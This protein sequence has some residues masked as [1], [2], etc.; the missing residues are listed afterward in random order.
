MTMTKG[1]VLFI[2]LFLVIAVSNPQQ[3]LASEE[4]RMQDEVIYM[5]MVDRFNN[6]N[7]SN[8][9][10]ANINDPLAYHGGDFQGITDKL[11]Y[12]KEMGYTAIWLTPI[13]ENMNNG[14]HGYWIK[15]FY[16]T[17]PY[18]GSMEEFKTLVTEAHKRDIKVILDFVVNHVGP[19]HEWLNDSTKNDWFHEKSLF[20]IGMIK[21]KLKTV[22][23][24]I[25]PI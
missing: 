24:M 21:K 19:N 15:D 11:D 20:L 10:D 2:L 7:T 3:S 17:N 25:Y 1:R 8:D 12:I 22:G 16:Q 9:K 23:Y 6:G 5:I 14:Y 18:F 13:F 4:K